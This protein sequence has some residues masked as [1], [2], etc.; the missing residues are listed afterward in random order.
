MISVGVWKI[1]SFVILNA[2]DHTFFKT[3]FVFSSP[4]I[5]LC[6]ASSLLQS[7]PSTYKGCLFYLFVL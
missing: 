5:I 3:Q 7:Q 2:F 1:K 4:C 6:E